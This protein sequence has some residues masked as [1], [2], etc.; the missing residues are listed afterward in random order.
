MSKA[1]AWQIRKRVVGSWLALGMMQRSIP[2]RRGQSLSTT[3]SSTR[4]RW[5]QPLSTPRGGRRLFSFECSDNRSTP[6]R[7][8]LSPSTGGGSTRSGRGQS[9]STRGGVGRWPPLTAARAVWDARIDDGAFESETTSC[10][11]ARDIFSTAA[12]QVSGARPGAD[13]VRLR[14]LQGGPSWTNA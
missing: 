4:G 5:G 3:G 6:R 8:G 2:C 14:S 7:R 10:R 9:P 11:D 12:G 13:H 1:M